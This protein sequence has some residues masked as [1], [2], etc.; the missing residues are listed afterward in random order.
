ML[1]IKAGEEK[2]QSVFAFRIRVI[3]GRRI[4]GDAS[5]VVEYGA[6]ERMPFH[7]PLWRIRVFRNPLRFLVSVFP[8]SE[9]GRKRQAARP[10]HRPAEFTQDETMVER[11][12]SAWGHFDCDHATSRGTAMDYERPE[13]ARGESGTAC[14]Q[15]LHTPQRARH[16]RLY[17]A[18][19]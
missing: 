9:R 12:R 5:L 16:L 10:H 7:F 11:K 3:A 17:A 13:C 18:R 2:Q 1:I 14:V 19:L 15:E 6:L 4:N 8:E